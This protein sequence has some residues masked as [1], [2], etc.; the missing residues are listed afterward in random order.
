MQVY[1]ELQCTG[2]NF[3]KGKFRMRLW[4]KLILLMSVWGSEDMFATEGECCYN[5]S[6]TTNKF[7]YEQASKKQKD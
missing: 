2:R 6:Y 3:L 1:H 5:D 7:G 4:G